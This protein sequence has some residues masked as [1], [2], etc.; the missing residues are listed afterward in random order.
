M[1][2]TD[3][4]LGQEACRRLNETHGRMKL[5]I[6][7]KD[8]DY[9]VVK[10]LITAMREEPWVPDAKP[11]H[12]MFPPPKEP[13]KGCISGWE[14]KEQA[15]TNHPDWLLEKAQTLW[16]ECAGQTAVQKIATAL[17]MEPPE[18]PVDEATLCLAAYD[19]GDGTVLGAITHALNWVDER[20]KTDA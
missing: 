8:K 20:R 14:V 7:P 11:Y 1:N 10:V 16:G 17:M 12:G 2:I 3:E 15:A 13:V 19:G 6:W 4:Q 18:P 5:W 9:Q